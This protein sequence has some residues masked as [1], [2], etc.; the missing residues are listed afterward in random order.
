MARFF[1]ARQAVVLQNGMPLALVQG[2]TQ[3][4]SESRSEIASKELEDPPVV[5]SGELIVIT[6]SQLLQS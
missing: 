3:S 6:P 4:T 1:Y 5:W 2:Y